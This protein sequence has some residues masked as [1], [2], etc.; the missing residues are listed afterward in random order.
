MWIT[1]SS[2][3]PMERIMK[4]PFWRLGQSSYADVLVAS[5]QDWNIKTTQS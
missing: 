3:V 5:N 4:R 2:T 1:E